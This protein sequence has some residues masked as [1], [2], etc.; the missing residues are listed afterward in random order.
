MKGSRRGPWATQRGTP[1][2]SGGARRN[3]PAIGVLLR[4]RAA[5]GRHCDLLP[6]DLFSYMFHYPHP[7]YAWRLYEFALR[8][9]VIRIHQPQKGLDQSSLYTGLPTSQGAIRNAM[10][11]YPITAWTFSSSS[12]GLNGLPAV[13]YKAATSTVARFCAGTTPSVSSVEDSHLAGSVL[14]CVQR[15]G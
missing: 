5:H 15:K 4:L 10:W 3:H 1:A 14:Q 11:S 9:G 13:P 8:Q 6:Y 12:R 2:E 7:Y